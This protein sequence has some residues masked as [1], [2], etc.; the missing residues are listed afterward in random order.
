MI[1]PGKPGDVSAKLSFTDTESDPSDGDDT[2]HL[3]KHIN[4]EYFMAY[5]DKTTVQFL[6]KNH[7]HKNVLKFILVYIPIF[8]DKISTTKNKV[9]E[10]TSNPGW[11]FLTSVPFKRLITKHQY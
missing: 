1:P 5:S 11:E 3:S 4:F 8:D 9:D 2:D 6:Q 10:T 7:Y